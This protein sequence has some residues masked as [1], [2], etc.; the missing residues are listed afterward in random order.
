MRRVFTALKRAAFVSVESARKLLHENARI[1]DVRT[2]SEFRQE[3][4]QGAIN[5]PLNELEA[6]VI[7]EIPE[8]SQILLV[9]CLSGG[10]S[11]IAKGKLRKLGYT[12][13]H[14]L[15]SLGR[16]MKVVQT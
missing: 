11:A 9:H 3:H 8:K 5:I 14:N 12:R 6:R 4:V 2:K 15:G 1:V 7:R 13:V 16:A 10:R